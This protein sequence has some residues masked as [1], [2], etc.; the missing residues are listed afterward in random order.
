[1]DNVIIQSLILIEW[2][3]SNAFECIHT[4]I[5]SIFLIYNNQQQIEKDDKTTRDSDNN[6]K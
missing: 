4:Y 6:N 2:Y 3:L 5:F 1:M